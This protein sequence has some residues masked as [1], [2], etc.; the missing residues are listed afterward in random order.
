M[1]KLALQADLWYNKHINIVLP[2]RRYQH[3]L[4]WICLDWRHIV[5]T[6]PPHAQNDNP[7]IPATGG[8]Y[9]IIC[10]LTEKIYVGS[11]VNLS[12]RLHHHF[13]HLRLNN[14]KNPKLQR[15]WNKYGEDAFTFEIL[16]LVLIPEMLTAREQYWFSKLNPFGKRGYNIARV[17]G[18]NL[19]GTHTPET[20]EKLR[21]A[22]LGK[23]LSPEHAEKSRKASLGNKL[24]P[25]QLE[26]RRGRVVSEETRAKRRGKKWTPEQKARLKA[27]RNTPEARE[28]NRQAHLGKTLSSETKEKLRQINLG[29][30]MPPE[31]IEKAWITRKSKKKE[32]G[33]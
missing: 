15:A 12:E 33:K 10:T 22:K 8:I 2:E 20:R 28:K 6:L 18:S 21:Q 27:T 9:R 25:E 30:K 24:T 17:A 26:R 4:A 19:G 16:E 32:T 31:S 29:K 11:A 23:K 7:K 14:H 13:S 3:P 1:S 5:N